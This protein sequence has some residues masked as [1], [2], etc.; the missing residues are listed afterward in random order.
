M[1]SLGIPQKGKTTLPLRDTELW[2]PTIPGENSSLVPGCRNSPSH[3]CPLLYLD[4]GGRNG[5]YLKNI[6]SVS[7]LVSRD[8]NIPK[9][10]K[11]EYDRPISG[12]KVRILDKWGVYDSD[13]QYDSSVTREI[14]FAI[15]GAS[16]EYITRVDIGHIYGDLE[17]FA[18][19]NVFPTRFPLGTENLAD[20]D[21]QIYTNWRRQAAF[22]SGRGFHE[23]FG[24]EISDESMVIT[25]IYIDV[26]EPGFYLKRLT[27]STSY[28]NM[29]I[30]KLF[31]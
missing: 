4:F 11:V 9:A 10:V 5:A 21:S 12:S 17:S 25:G 22:P 7:L 29:P 24:E 8:S 20:N 28:A 31:W 1:V 19:F 18:D 2:F 14:K 13:T 26:S 23:P 6:V 30:A 15:D 16:G 3:Y 27:L